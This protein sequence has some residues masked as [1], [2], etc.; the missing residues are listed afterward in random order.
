MCI[1]IYIYMAPEFQPLEYFLPENPGRTTDVFG[2]PIAGHLA[3]PP[4]G[5]DADPTLY[6]YIYIEREREREREPFRK[7]PRA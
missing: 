4:R 2:K 3:E 6:I 1:Y 7:P 5:R